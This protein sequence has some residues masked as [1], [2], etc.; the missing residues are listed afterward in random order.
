M[1]NH[2]IDRSELPTDSRI[3]KWLFFLSHAYSLWLLAKLNRFSAVWT[4][5]IFW[6]RI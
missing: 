2:A 4:K 3:G 5:E 1:L 6:A